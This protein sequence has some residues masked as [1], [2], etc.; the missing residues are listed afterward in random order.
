MDISALRKISSSRLA[1][2]AF[3]LLAGILTGLAPA[4]AGLAQSWPNRPITIV[5]GLA[6][7]GPTDTIARVIADAM[8][9]SLGQPVI[10]ENVTGASCSIAVGRVV[11]VAPDGY[12]VSIG[13]WGTHVTHGTIYALP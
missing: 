5:A 8:R 12:T 9:T 13:Q 1:L 7:G 2:R 10:V 3:V 11:R 6:P 4:A